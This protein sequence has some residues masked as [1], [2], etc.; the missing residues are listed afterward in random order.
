M[1]GEMQHSNNAEKF[2]TTFL[3]CPVKQEKKFKLKGISSVLKKMSSFFETN[4][5]I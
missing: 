5:C 3:N 1:A 4:T 2:R